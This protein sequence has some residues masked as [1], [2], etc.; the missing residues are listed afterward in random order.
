ME[1][2]LAPETGASNIEIMEY[3]LT[4]VVLWLSE[5]RLSSLSILSTLV[6]IPPTRHATT[7]SRLFDRLKA[8]KLVVEGK[9]PL[10]RN[11]ALFMAGPLAEDYLLYRGFARRLLDSYDLMNSHKQLFHDLSVQRAMVARL[12]NAVDI[13]GEYQMQLEADGKWENQGLRMNRPDAVIRTVHDQ[14]FAYEYEWTRKSQARIYQAFQSHVLALQNQIYDG[15]FYLFPSDQVRGKYESY[16]RPAVW[17][18]Y[19]RNK[20]KGHLIREDAYFEPGNW[21]KKFRF[22]TENYYQQAKKVVKLE[23]SQS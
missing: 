18:L 11:D 15:V 9:H 3:R 6:G 21:R 5:F 1:I 13:R 19:N 14:V 7:T 22:K 2:T 8:M 20:E 4:R 17:P 23:E 10:L 16:F 12:A